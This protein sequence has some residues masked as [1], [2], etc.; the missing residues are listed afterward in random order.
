[1][2][3]SANG[4]D[5]LV[6]SHDALAPSSE[7]DKEQA[8]DEDERVILNV[9]GQRFEVSQKTLTKYPDTHLGN[10]FLPSNKHLRKLDKRGEY[11]IDRNPRFFEVIL[12]YYRTGKLVVPSDAPIDLLKEELRFYKLKLE[13]EDDDE[14][15]DYQPRNPENAFPTAFSLIQGGRWEIQQGIA[16]LEELIEQEQHSNEKEYLYYLAIAYHRMGNSA[17]ANYYNQ[18][19]LALD[20]HNKE[21]ITLRT[22]NKDKASIT[23]KAGALFFVFVT[24]SGYFLYKSNGFSL[25]RSL[26]RKQ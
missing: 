8:Y 11:F 18:K 17:K 21:A 23:A 24:I 22:L 4:H 26:R 14:P 16:L 9:G 19:V 25:F 10:L 1:M 5:I 15:E 12:D 20:P 6:H 13:D 7:E 3:G 2:E